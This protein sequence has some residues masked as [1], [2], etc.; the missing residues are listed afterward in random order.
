MNGIFDDISELVPHIL[1]NPRSCRCKKARQTRIR[2]PWTF[3]QLMEPAF[4]IP[5]SKWQIFAFIPLF[6]ASSEIS[7]KCFSK[8]LDFFNFPY[9][10]PRVCQNNVSGLLYRAKCNRGWSP[11]ESG[12]PSTTLLETS[13][14]KV[15][16]TS[17]WEPLLQYELYWN[18]ATDDKL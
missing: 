5:G 9:P 4:S 2:C 7:T 16:S 10:T 17:T 6:L 18:L 3:W 13:L 1:T 8:I 15:V 11:T 14:V 12:Q